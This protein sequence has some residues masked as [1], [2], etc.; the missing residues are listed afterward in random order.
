MK[1]N[2]IIIVQRE[3][4]SPTKIERDTKIIYCWNGRY[5]RGVETDEYV[6]FCNYQECDDNASVKMYSKTTN[7]LL[8]DNYH[9]FNHLI[10]VILDKTYT[11]LSHS[12]KFNASEMRKQNA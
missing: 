8:S 11:Y 6:Y 2:S 10:G 5:H 9:A 4:S 1:T 3:E 7:E 12:M